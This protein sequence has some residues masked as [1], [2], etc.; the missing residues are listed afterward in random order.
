[1]E[2]EILSWSCRI[3]AFRSRTWS[4]RSFL[5]MS[6]ELGIDLVAT[7]DVH[8]TYAERCGRHMIFCFVCRPAKAAG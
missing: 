7:N 6:K 3:M 5:R 2:K 8:Y 1:M 4:I